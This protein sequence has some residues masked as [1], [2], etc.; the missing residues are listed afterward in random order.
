MFRRLAIAAPPRLRSRSLGLLVSAP[1]AFAHAQLLGT[2]PASGATVPTQPQEVIFEFNQN[3]GGTLGAVRVYNAQGDEVDNLAVSHPDGNE[4]WM[5]VG[6]QAGAARR[7]LHRH[8]PGDLRRHPHRLRRPGLQHRPSRRR[9]Q[10]HRRRADRAQQERQGHRDRLRDRSRP[11]L[12]HDRRADRW[13]G[14][15]ASSRG[16]PA[17]WPSPAAAPS[18]GRPG[19]PSRGACACC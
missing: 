3:V 15:P 9:P 18:G 11:G 13:T 17:S 1:G 6:P 19:A 12:P 16:C 4:H 5:G 7:H 14:L 10:V 8:L 2:S